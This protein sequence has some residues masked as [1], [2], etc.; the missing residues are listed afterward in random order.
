MIFY[1]IELATGTQAINLVVERGNV[2]PT[3]TVG[4]APDNIGRLFFNT[5]DNILYVWGNSQWDP[6]GFQGISGGYVATVNGKSGNVVIT[7]DDILPQIPIATPTTLGLVKIGTGLSINSSGLLTTTVGSGGS[8]DLSAYAP[9]NSPV[10]TGV[11]QS[12]T[13][14]TGTNTT[15]IATTAFVHSAISS[16]SYSLSPIDYINVSGHNSSAVLSNG[17]LYTTS[18]NAGGNGAHTSG[19][20]ISSPPAFGLNNFQQV[21]FPFTSSPV[22]K[23]G[24]YRHNVAY[25]LMGNGE[26]YTWGEN[27]HGQCGLG[28]TITVPYPTLAQT[29]VVDVF[30]HPTN[31]E[32]GLAN[33][34]IIKKTDGFLYAAG[35]NG[36]GQLGVGDT[37]NKTTFT[38]IT[39]LGTDIK[40][41]WNLGS[42]FGCTVVCK[43]DDSIWVAGR[44]NYGQ[45]GTGDTTLKN[46]F[47]DVTANWGG[48]IGEV[49]KVS[50]TCGGSSNGSDQYSYGLMA[51]LRKNSSDVT[52]VYTCGNNSYGAIGNSS[53]TSTSTPFLVP[54]SNSVK[55]IAVFGAHAQTIQMLNND[56]SLYAWGYNGL[57]CVGNGTSAS[58]ITVPTLV[59]NGVKRLLSD[60]QATYLYGWYTQAFIEKTDNAI[61]AVGYDDSTGYT[62]TGLTS[63][64][65]SYTRV[66]LPPGIRVKFLGST[67]TTT[68]GK[69][70]ILVTEENRMYAWGYNGH[71]AITGNGGGSCAVPSAYA[72]RGIGE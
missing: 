18:G 1:G 59:Q 7:A 69:A 43:T 31:G 9:I 11:P 2:N 25:A 64:V 65:T 40:S 32:F 20:F 39:S 70:Y 54:N 5:V 35:Y 17:K 16:S 21:V 27:N 41:V 45:L 3:F 19:R 68:H 56:G 34:L 24:G 8:V 61:Y 30:D 22:V 4:T 42:T 37:V 58:P 23:T 55:D 38:K 29:N 15:Q 47:V 67:A 36:Y 44:N 63:T 60:G 57:G 12:P 72:L 14:T 13:A 48:N 62:G 71:A 51:I 50:F 28:H 53:T 26:L 49:L 33:K 10:L 52:A 46:T 6:L 66:R